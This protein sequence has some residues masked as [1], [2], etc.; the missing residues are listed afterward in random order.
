M[1]P[2]SLSKREHQIMEIL[3]RRGQASAAEVHEELPSAPSYSAT[4]AMLST[5]LRKGHIKHRTC[6][7]RY[8]Y[9]PYQPR[10]KAAASALT[11]VLET[12]FSGSASAA[13]AGILETRGTKL[14]REE[15]D[16]LNRLI[17]EA[18][19]DEDSG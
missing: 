7:G 11:Q 2:D 17:E 1:K 8:V 14:S 3:Y 19:R 10:R 6:R 12:F 9:Q 13:I 4:R 5:L 18:A 15:A 16:R